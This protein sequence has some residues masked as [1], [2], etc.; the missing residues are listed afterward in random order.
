MRQ[1]KCGNP[2]DSTMGHLLFLIH[3][4][5]LPRGKN[6]YSKPSVLSADDTCVLNT[7]NNIN[8]ILIRSATILNYM[9][10]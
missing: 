10:K 1:Q 9:S 5:D 7:A 4:Y 2:Q 3:I 8:D 6:T